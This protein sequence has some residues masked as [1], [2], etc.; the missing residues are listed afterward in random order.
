MARI[1]LTD[2]ELYYLA[3]MNGQNI[4]VMAMMVNK[5]MPQMPDLKIGQQI[6]AKFA[7]VLRGCL[8]DPFGG[9]SSA[10]A[11]KGSSSRPAMARQP[12]SKK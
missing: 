10:Q 1:D 12:R 9:L 2:D 4:A 8:P 11:A 6:Q 5:G 3:K 7:A